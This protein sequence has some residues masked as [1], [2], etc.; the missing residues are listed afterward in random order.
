MSYSLD[1]MISAQHPREI[2]S[3]LGQGHVAIGSGQDSNQTHLCCEQIT[4]PLCSLPQWLSICEPEP[5]E[6][7]N[8]GPQ[9]DFRK[10]HAK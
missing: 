9:G 5:G 6:V 8:G 3:S 7:A 10:G 4:C 1:L 2:W